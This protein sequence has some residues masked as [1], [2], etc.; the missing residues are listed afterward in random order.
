[1]FDTRGGKVHA[2]VLRHANSDVVQI[3]ALG[4]GVDFHGAAH[5]F[6]HRRLRHPEGRMDGDDDDVKLGESLVVE[7]QASSIRGAVDRP[8]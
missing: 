8:P 7:A 5:T 4:L 2:G 1:M 3:E 6:G